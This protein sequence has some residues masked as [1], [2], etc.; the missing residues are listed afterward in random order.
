MKKNK[1]VLSVMLVMII[2]TVG[3]FLRYRNF[4]AVPLPGEST[5]EYSNTWVGL[6][7]IELGL[8]VG[9]SGLEGYGGN[10]FRYINVDQIFSTTAGGN[11]LGINHPWLDHPP[12]LPLISGG[13][14][15]ISGARVFEDATARI[16]RKPMLVMG[17]ATIA[18]VGYLSF[19]ISGVGAALLTMALFASSPLLVVTSRM[20]QGENGVVIGFLLA[21]IFLY[22]YLDK[23]K[24][25]FLWLAALSSGFAVLFKVSGMSVAI[26]GT[27][28]LLT[29]ENK[30]MSEKFWE[31]ALFLVVSGSFLALYFVYGAAFS[32][33]T[34]MRVW[35][36]NSARPYDIGFGSLFDLLTVTKIT[37]GKRLTEGWPLMGWMSLFILMNSK[38]K[39]IFYFI[40]LPTFV[41]LSIFLLMG[42]NSYGWYRI[43][44]MPFLFLAAA[45]ILADGYGSRDKLLPVF[46]VLF[47]LGVTVHKLNE[48][49]PLVFLT[50]FWRLFLPL[51]IL[52]FLIIKN[53]QTNRWLYLTLIL[54]AIFANVVLAYSLTPGVWLKM[55]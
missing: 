40:I 18:L 34:F 15:Y 38:T 36:S 6:S 25:L 44:F 2:L 55:N 47:P 19:L 8:P 10:D 4:A 37:I 32:W 48:V 23:K 35:S 41:Y 27:F 52:W 26:C 1:S 7:L 46:L 29:Q 45:A 14:A 22:I 31:S 43:P 30:K 16:I 5:D 3:F 24:L 11:P 53:E 13:Y 33:S 21:L 51:M 50:P 39:R 20:V 49:S 42:G 28:I 12:L 54:M 9:R 17:I